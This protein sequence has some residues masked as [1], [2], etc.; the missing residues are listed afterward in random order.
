MALARISRS[1]IRILTIDSNN[2]VVTIGVV[3]RCLRRRCPLSLESSADYV[4]DGNPTCFT[5]HPFDRE[6]PYSPI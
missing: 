6:T 3:G 4:P 1:L 2:V 5:S